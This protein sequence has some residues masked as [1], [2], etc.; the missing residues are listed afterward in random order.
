[1]KPLG[2]GLPPV[3][4][5]GAGLMLAFAMLWAGAAPLVD[6][7]AG[8]R[9]PW[10]GHVTTGV[11]PLPGAHLAHIHPYE[12]PHRHD[13]SRAAPFDTGSGAE[14]VPGL[15]LMT[16]APDPAPSSTAAPLG[17]GALDTTTPAAVP[18]VRGGT[19][20]AATVMLF[21]MALDSVT[22]PPEPGLV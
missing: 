16:H 22:P 14:A 5:V 21:G 7:H 4:L 2:F 6:H 3:L 18:F 17:T 9:D 1:M 11:L 15:V 8:E 19:A 20:D 13:R 12:L 10:H